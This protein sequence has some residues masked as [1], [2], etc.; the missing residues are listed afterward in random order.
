MSVSGLVKNIE[1]KSSELR[2]LLRMSDSEWTRQ[3]GKLRSFLAEN[4]DARCRLWPQAPGLNFVLHPSAGY[5]I[6]RLSIFCGWVGCG[7][8]LVACGAYLVGSG[9]QP[10]SLRV[11]KEKV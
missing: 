3:L 5:S 9:A 2:A 6:L 11:L 1:T 10:D 7:A 4:S 8:H